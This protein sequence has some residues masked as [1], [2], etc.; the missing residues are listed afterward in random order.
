MQTVQ[1]NGS[2]AGT[3]L[4]TRLVYDKYGQVIEN[5]LPVPASGNNGACVSFFNSKSKSAYNDSYAYT[6]TEYEPSPLARPVAV[7]SPGAE[8]KSHPA[9]IKYATNYNMNVKKYAMSSK[10][11]IVDKGTYA[12]GSLFVKIETDQDG[13]TTQTF[14]DK[15]GNVILERRVNGS[16]NY[17]TYYVYSNYDTYDS[18]YHHSK[19]CAVMPPG[20]NASNYAEAAYIYRYD[21]RRRCIYKK[22]PGA[23]PVTYVY[24]N[25]DRITY[26]QDGEQRNRCVYTYYVYDQFGRVTS[27][28]ECTD[29]KGNNKTQLI[30]NYYDGY[31][32][33]QNK[34]FKGFPNNS[35]SAQ[36]LKTGS[37][38]KVLG[39]T[40]PNNIQYE[41][42]YYDYRGRLE[43]TV[44]KDPYGMMVTYSTTYNYNNQVTKQE[45]T[46][47]S[48]YITKTT[49]N[50]YDKQ[51]R[52][53]KE[54]T[55]V[56]EM[57][58]Q[59][60]AQ[61]EFVYS[62]VG[63]L[64]SKKIGTTTKTEINY[65]YNTQGQLLSA[66]STPFTEKLYY[67]NS[68][69]PN[70]KNYF[71]GNISAIY[72]KH[73]GQSANT[74]IFD[75]DK[76]NRLV[77]STMLVGT[78]YTET[79]FLY[80]E[81]GNISGF[82]RYD[83]S[84]QPTSYYLTHSNANRLVIANTDKG[85]FWGFSYDANGNQTT[86]PNGLTITYNSI[87]Q[88]QQVKSGSTVKHKFAYLADGRKLHSISDPANDGG[89]AY[90]GS[91]VFNIGRGNYT[92]F[93]ST[94]FS[95]GRIV[96]NGN[97]TYTV[98]YHITDHLGSVRAVLNQSMTVLEQNDYYPFGLRH[99]NASL[100][101]IANRY[102]YN[103]KEEISTTGISDYGARQY[104]AEFCQWLQVDPLAESFSSISP[105]AFVANNPILLVDPDG[106]YPRWNGKYGDEC[107][108]YDSNTNEDLSWNQVQNY[109]NFG[110]YD[111]INELEN[112]NS[113]PNKTI[114]PFGVGVEWL[115][116]HGERSR[117]F[118]GGDYFTELLRKHDNIASTKKIIAEKIKNGK[119]HDTEL[120]GLNGIQGVGK[121]IKDYSTLLTGGFTGNLAATYLGSYN[122]DW[123]VIKIAG[124][125]ATVL[126]EVTNSSTI[127]SACRPPVLG[128]LSI[129]KNTVGSTLNSIFSSGP[130]SKTTQK[131]IWSE[132]IS[133]K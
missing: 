68:S 58:H 126:F 64:G 34:E 10:N 6:K 55:T 106:R 91:S 54:S 96:R 117:T 128:Y 77:N 17:D 113:V 73:S 23:D 97:G 124:N 60:T 90:I 98:Q 132:K 67:N 93:E 25:A 14:T 66:A 95:A 101:T 16:E 28:G 123:S 51:R 116:G 115:T 18:R 70:A 2:A 103:G 127:Q 72:W 119:F 44:V 35:V 56:N 37:I 79:G 40:E 39:A 129:W 75:Y 87:N 107:G 61:V 112:S 110:S 85:Q 69:I 81:R 32:F 33:R 49:T 74:T 76:L 30:Y 102:R 82:T 3:D 114:T 7:Y 26:S 59:A 84:S 41:V 57:N 130:A 38:I 13:C 46:Y 121:Y 20:C 12:N 1:V 86:A 88:P 80:D 42:Y 120:Y 89:L 11:E 36:G 48:L 125:E 104:G 9:T 21:E 4:A 43:K 5:W 131:L 99:P 45:E 100:K 31:W 65:Q 24:D 62:N 71:N 27:Q 53:T 47:S 108:Y 78:P 8:M 52:L 118:V 111:G 50:T 63:R 133:I 122:L 15:L 83:A 94:S 22:I 19:L 109:I 29:T 92:S 105:Y